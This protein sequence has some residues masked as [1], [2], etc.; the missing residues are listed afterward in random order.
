MGHH[1]EQAGTLLR[2]RES[3]SVGVYRESALCGH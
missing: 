2:S 3:V 1:D